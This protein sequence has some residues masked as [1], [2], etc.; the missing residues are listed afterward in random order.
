MADLIVGYQVP[1]VATVTD[2]YGNVIETLATPEWAV[3]DPSLASVDAAGLLVAGTKVGD[4]VVSATVEG[5]V[6]TLAVSLKPDAP[7]AVAVAFGGDP[8]PV[9]APEPAPEPEPPP[10]E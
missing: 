6:G 9:P 2:K 5:I 3:D 4:V 1:L 7:A 10:T 8:Q